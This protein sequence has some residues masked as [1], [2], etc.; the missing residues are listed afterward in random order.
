MTRDFDTQA[1]REMRAEREHDELAT[2]IDFIGEAISEAAS[3]DR[4]L[5]G[6]I[7]LYFADTTLRD[8]VQLAKIGRML[9][10]SV[11]SYA[12]DKVG[13]K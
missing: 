11:D 5:A 3:F 1:E 6:Q 10:E 9:V 13:D 4:E 8:D 2:D 7:M 12:W